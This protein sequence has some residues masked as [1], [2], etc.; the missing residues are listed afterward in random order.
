MVE[1]EAGVVE[2]GEEVAQLG[3]M[4]KAVENNSEDEDSNINSDTHSSQD[5]GT[6]TWSQLIVSCSYWIPVFG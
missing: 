3:E 1:V 6:I 4:E 2:V 5:N